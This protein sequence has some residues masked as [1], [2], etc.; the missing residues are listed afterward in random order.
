MTDKPRIAIVGGG[1]GGSTLAILLQVAGYQVKVY[2]QMAE[3]LRIGFGIDLSANA[4]R[5]MRKIGVEARLR[6]PGFAPAQRLSRE[7]DTGRVLFAHLVEEWG[8]KYGTDLVMPRSDLNEALLSGL[9]PGTVVFGKRLLDLTETNTSIELAFADG[10]KAESDI[11]VGA[12]G[13]NSRVREILLGPQRP[14]YSGVIA[15][16]SGFPTKLLGDFKVEADST[17]WWGSDRH[18]ITYYL[19][20]ARD[21]ISFI[22]G[23]PQKA[24]DSDALSMPADKDEIRAA[25]VGFHSEVQRVIEACPQASKWPL[26][27]RDPLPLW[28]R[29]RIVLLGDACHPMRPHMGQGA[30]QAMEDAVILA[31]CLN[32]EVDSDFLE[33]FRRYEANRIGRTSK[34]QQESQKN[35]W[36]RHETDPDWVY[37]YDAFNV[38][39]IPA[40]PHGVGDRLKMQA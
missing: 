8:K 21:E 28:S 4:T 7:W 22:S 23:S 15:Y 39:L 14:T 13:I 25:F 34:I 12:D 11:V 30:C 10:T 20:E 5:I 33:A 40:P 24:W 19:T 27:T 31:R 38:P 3:F 36:M 2:E 18:F 16:R 37:S 17:K 29:G 6:K 35:Q 26:M 32:D 9:E 1:L